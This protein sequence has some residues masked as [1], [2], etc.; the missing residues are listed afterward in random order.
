MFGLLIGTAC[1]V[2]LIAVLRRGRGRWGRRGHWGWR[3]R[4]PRR[5]LNG[6]F[7]RLETSPS[8]EKVI[9]SAVEG[10]REAMFSLRGEG[11]TT[12]SDLA[13]ILSE[14]SFDAERLAAVFTRHDDALRRVR[15]TVSGAFAEVHAVLDARQRAELARLVE[16]GGYW[17][18]TR[19]GPYREGVRI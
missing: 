5:F 10:V 12:R 1:L 15:D 4:G 11:E 17:R 7:E 13:H 8:Q 19:G 14:E 16:Q 6:L 3:G 2:G 9:M 18:R